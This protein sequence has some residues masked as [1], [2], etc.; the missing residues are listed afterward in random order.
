MIVLVADTSVLIDL[1]RGG[2]LDSIFSLPYAFAVPAGPSLV[3]V[4][5][6]LP[7]EPIPA[8]TLDAGTRTM[9]VRLAE[10]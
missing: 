5:G 1:H 2:L 9:I 7:A 4:A 3:P 10:I 8:Q 6:A